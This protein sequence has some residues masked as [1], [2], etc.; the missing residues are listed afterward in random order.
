[1]YSGRCILIGYC[2]SLWNIAFIQLRFRGNCQL[3]VR[4]LLKLLLTYNIVFTICNCGYI[5]FDTLCTTFQQPHSADT[6]FS[7]QLLIIIL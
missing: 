4:R 6:I 1:M 5:G 7:V 3:P 2:S